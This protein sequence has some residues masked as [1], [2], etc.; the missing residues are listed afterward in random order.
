MSKLQQMVTL[1]Q[2]T[3][4]LIDNQAKERAYTANF[5]N[6]QAENY[7]EEL[8]SI[9]KEVDKNYQE[10]NTRLS[11]RN[12]VPI[13]LKKDLISNLKEVK[14]TLN[15]VREQIKHDNLENVRTVNALNFY[16]TINSQLL[17]L[18]LEISI[19]ANEPDIVSQ[20]IA[21]YNL[22]S[23]KDD[24]ELINSF[25]NNLLFELDNDEYEEDELQ[26]IVTYNQ[27]KLKSLLNSEKE[28]LET[29]Y[30]LTS[31]IELKKYKEYIE[32]A[33]LSE[34]NDF[35]N[36][37]SNDNE[38]DIYAG[39]NEFFTELSNKKIVAINNMEKSTLSN[40]INSIKKYQT[41]AELSL[42]SNF[43]I[44]TIV[45]TLTL[46][47]GF[48][49]FRKINSDM[50][51]LKG[52]LLDFFDFLSKKKENINIKDVQGK[53]EF[54]ILINTINQEVLKTKEITS[55]DNI[56]LDEID[57]V[58][59]R[60]ENGFF[61]YT[62][63]NTAGSD[64]VESLKNS[65]N[66]MI[67]ITKNKLDILGLILD[68]YGE[69]KYNFRLTKEQ[70]K[71]IAGN[72]GT[73]RASLFALGND[74]STFMATF[75]RVIDNL[76]EN[77]NILTKASSSLSQATEVQ[78]SSIQQTVVSIDDITKSIQTNTHNIS[79]ISHLSDELNET[80]NKGNTLAKNT[81]EAMDEINQ[82]VGEINEAIT[83]IDQIAFQTN[84]LS[85]NAAVE[86][87]TAGEAG[88]GFAVVAQ[89]V[90]NLANKSA[91]AAKQIQSLVEEASK[92]ANDG[93][94]VSSSMIEGY[95]E[96]K[97]KIVETKDIIDNVNTNSQEQ[98]DKIIQINDAVIQL[99]NMTN[100]TTSSVQN[101]STLS[102]EIEDLS[103]QMETTISKAEF[104]PE[105]KE[106]VC[107]VEL[108][109]MVSK[110]KHQHIEFKAEH[111]KTLNEFKDFKIID[112]KHCKL[113]LWISEEEQKGSSFTQTSQWNKLKESHE[114]IHKNIQDYI[115]LNSQHLS[116]KQLEEKAE[117]IEDNTLEIFSNLNDVLKANC[118]D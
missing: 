99:D 82:K 20:I 85:L 45:L 74:I 9:R 34:Y 10:L 111:F 94:T 28:K 80:A 88:K 113:G 86:A 48:N 53:D 90:R 55:K 13:E 115:T 32:K 107:D 92:K 22:L 26:N 8:A 100:Q 101:L 4:V 19:Y 27:L 114:T 104:D 69:Y 118:P 98:N 91:E 31:K 14:K 41:N 102:K 81:S 11:I 60:V 7:V 77:T 117:N 33:K 30:K 57:E 112:C 49:I 43:A 2:S 3:V 109:D 110:H 18:L 16:T 37:L 17:K 64:S 36:S 108:A 51:L 58:I 78:A 96:L 105:Y 5:I 72:I 97:N 24:T 47:L 83:I 6:S 46:I 59:S 50:S 42:V 39:E 61:T 73:L 116:Q 1:V 62:V 68:A 106:M 93:K 71:G 25:G 21:T 95:S 84:I 75:S 79:K 44:A 29:F 12:Q 66:N 38:V 70:R 63:K 54:A 52:N 87:A 76:N 15:S 89:E 67:E 65:V 23:S 35:I 103:K 56:V 40:I